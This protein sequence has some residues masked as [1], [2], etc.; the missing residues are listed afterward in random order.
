[1]D[2][3]IH[4]RRR[5]L[6]PLFLLISSFLPGPAF[7][8]TPSFQE[9]PVFSSGEGGYHT[10]RIPAIT[11]TTDGTLLAFCEGRKNSLS[12]TGDI[13]LLLRRSSD[14]GLTWGPIIVVWDDGSN[15]CGNPAPVVDQTTG[16]LWLLSTWNHGSDSESKIVNRTAI[17]TRRVFV[18]KSEDDS[19]SWSTAVD[20]TT[21]TKQANWTWYATG[22]GGGI[23]LQRGTQA[24]RLAVACDHKTDTG[25][26]G[27]HVIFSDDQG[28]TWQIGAVAFQTGTVKP[29]ENLAVELIAPAP[30]GGSQLYFN[31]RDHQGPHARATTFSLDGGSGYSPSQL[32]D[33]PNFI[34]PVVQ[35]GLTRFFGTDLGDAGNRLLFSCPNASTRTRLSIWSSLDEAQT[36]SGPRLVYEGPS[37][38]SDMARIDAAT[39]GLLYERGASSPYETIT[40]ARFNAEWLDL[41][42]PPSENPSAAF[43][44]LDER[45]PGETAST[46][47]GAIFDLHPDENALHLTASK[48]FPVVAGASTYGDGRALAFNADGGLSISDAASDNAF[49]YGAG[50][51]FTIEIVCRVPAGSTQTGALVAKDLGAFSPS[52]WLRVEDGK[53]RFLISDTAAEPNLSS[54][55][56][57]NDGAWHHI[58]AVRDSSDPDNK[59][60]RIY[61]NGQAAGDV[62]DTTTQSLANAQALW[63]GRF[64]NGNH[65]FTGDIDFVRITPAALTPADFVGTYTQLD[66]DSDFVPDA[67]ERGRTGSLSILGS[68]DSNGNGLPD[69]ADFALGADPLDSES[70]P[71]VDILPGT[72]QIQIILTQRDLP[73]WIEVRVQA[74]VDLQKW[75]PAPG[76]FLL[77]PLEDGLWMRTHT[78]PYPDG[79]PKRAFY[80]ANVLIK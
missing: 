10:Y 57:V 3:M 19:L 43:W 58:S 35:G 71:S 77:D 23:Q 26:F 4:F 8:A 13:D 16:T 47:S 70:A 29:N 76:S 63:I 46:A 41:P 2:V 66:A 33:A 72:D 59:R 7:A 79:L 64:N 53:A 75:D 65:L 39:M 48:A 67:Y 52:W 32:T 30:D 9:A 21:D 36:W 5:T 1:M 12:D 28:L 37:A 54:T 6:L 34:T 20:I 42:P 14:G 62:A 69:Y 61:I 24:G 51:S 45:A 73:P 50:D 17:D 60:L 40:F 49:D 80:R 55:V 25:A 78:A 74:S 22:P 27:S 56:A 11:Q 44:T 38:Y 15:T 31:A 18:Q 68:G